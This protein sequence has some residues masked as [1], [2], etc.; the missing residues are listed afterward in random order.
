MFGSIPERRLSRE[1]HGME[2]DPNKPYAPDELRGYAMYFKSEV[3]RVEQFK[4][5]CIS[6]KHSPN[7]SVMKA[8]EEYLERLREKQFA[9]SRQL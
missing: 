7:D 9:V 8:I 1:R 5:W 2:F 6:E 3:Q 4:A